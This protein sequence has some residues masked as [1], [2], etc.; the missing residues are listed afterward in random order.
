MDFPPA[1]IPVNCGQKQIIFVQ[2]NSRSP[3][4]CTGAS[5]RHGQKSQI[6]M[7]SK[8]IYIENA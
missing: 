3:E 8:E 6:S 5:P 1:I 4:Q 2:V 7:F